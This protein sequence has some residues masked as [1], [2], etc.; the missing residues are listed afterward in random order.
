MI[1]RRR[2][3]KQDKEIEK[4]YT[5]KAVAAKLRRLADSLENSKPCQIQ[6]AGERIHIPPTATV[7]FEYSR[8]GAEEEVEIEVKWRRK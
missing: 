3:M 8:N 7:E 1:F 2:A 4:S 6:I 5:K